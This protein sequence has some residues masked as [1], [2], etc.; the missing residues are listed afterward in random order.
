MNFIFSKSIIYHYRNVRILHGSRE[1]HLFVSII[2]LM[3]SFIVRLVAIAL[4]WRLQTV[5]LRIY[6]DI[7]DQVAAGHLGL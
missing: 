3:K 2:Y 1:R 5:L 6:L 4:P 7:A